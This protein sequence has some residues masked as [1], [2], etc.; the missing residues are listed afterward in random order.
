MTKNWINVDVDINARKIGRGLDIKGPKIG[1]TGLDIHGPKFDARL[2]IHGPK[3][4]LPK[5]DVDINA[6]IIGGG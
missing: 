4:G 5:V 2:D 3:I 6:P 1:G